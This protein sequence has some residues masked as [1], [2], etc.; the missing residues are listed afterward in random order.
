MPGLVLLKRLLGA[1]QV[2]GQT[3]TITDYNSEK[4]L[5]SYATTIMYNSINVQR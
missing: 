5:T 3:I 4:A 1:F 2:L